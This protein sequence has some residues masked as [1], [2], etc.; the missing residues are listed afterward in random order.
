M[1]TLIF[2]GIVIL[3]PLF[4]IVIYNGIIA[5]DNRVHRAW[6]DVVAYER[7]KIKVIEQIQTTLSD[8]KDFEKELLNNITQLRTAVGTLSSE[9]IDH[10]SLGNAELLS[11]NLLS[12]LKVAV[13][14]YPDLKA[15]KLAQQYMREVSEQQSNITAAIAIFNAA[16]EQFNNAIQQFPGSLV[17]SLALKM[18][19]RATFEDTQASDAFEFRP[20]NA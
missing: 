4:G 16:V 14:A 15:Q 9:K 19:P 5:G 6:G 20:N 10:S 18:S 11:K 17:N 13:E 1:L 7:N 2:L 12:G 3:V 8:Y